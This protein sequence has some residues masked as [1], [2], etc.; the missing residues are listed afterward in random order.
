MKRKPFAIVATCV[1]LAVFITG[2]GEKSES[3]SVSNK[4]V[5]LVA[6][7]GETAVVQTDFTT[8]SKAVGDTAVKASDKDDTF[9]MLSSENWIGTWD[10][11]NHT[12]LWGNNIQKLTFDRI[13]EIDPVTNDLVPGLAES[14]EYEGNTLIVHLRKGVKFHDGSD[15][16]AEDAKYSIEGNA[17]PDNVTS[18]IWVEP[19][20]VSIVDDYTVRVDTEPPRVFRR[21]NYMR[22]LC[23]GKT[24]Q[25]C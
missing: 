24:N 3:S 22:G 1:L 12:S 8:V 19:L 9:V 21:H 10:P 23:Y 13:V 6:A 14:W 7:T 17:N 25:V 15:W 11:N 5:E 4:S 16:T 2:C 18:M 20:K